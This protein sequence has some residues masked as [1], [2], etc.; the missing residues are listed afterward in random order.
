MGAI[1]IDSNKDLNSGIAVG[2]VIGNKNTESKNI[3][4]W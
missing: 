3:Y 2:T 1:Y 4:I